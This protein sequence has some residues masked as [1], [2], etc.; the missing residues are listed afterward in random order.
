MKDKTYKNSKEEKQRKG[1]RIHKKIGIRAFLK[2][3]GDRTL[4][5][6]NLI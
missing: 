5:H 3:K 2:N 4:C 1:C 6:L